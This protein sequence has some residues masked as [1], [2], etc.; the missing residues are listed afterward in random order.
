M[1]V[2]EPDSRPLS[3]LVTPRAT[4][5]SVSRPP[6]RLLPPSVPL[7]SLPSSASSPCD[8][9]TG[10]PTLVSLTPCPARSLASA[11]PS[12]SVY[13]HQQ[14]KR[15]SSKNKEH[16][17][18]DCFYSSSP[19]P[20]VLASLPLPP[21]SD[22]SSSPVS[23]TPTPPPP[24]PQRPSR[25]PSRLPLWPS[26]TPTASLPPTSGRRPSSSRAPWTSMPTHCER[27][28]DTRARAGKFYA[29]SWKLVP[30]SHD[31]LCFIA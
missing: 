24:V 9:V 30:R 8:E 7:S 5:V 3:S 18:T 1:P 4:S 27:V 20:V 17:K 31:S 29:G 19:L 10:V 15:I 2:S 21:S 26:P 14:E 13:V 22:S 23:R 11:V 25:T 28:S 16:E 6:R 12:P